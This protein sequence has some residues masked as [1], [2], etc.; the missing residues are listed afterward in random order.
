MPKITLQLDTK[1][2]IPLA[3]VI[4]GAIIALA[5]IFSGGVSLPSKSGNQPSSQKEEAK[6]EITVTKENNVQGNFE[7]PVTIIEFSDFQ[8]PFCQSFHPTLQKILAEFPNQVR[9]VYRH[10]PLDQ[11]HPQARPAAEAS[12]C[13]AEQGKFWEFADGLFENQS[14]L[15]ESFYKELASQLGLNSNQFESCIS[16]RKY[17]DKVESDYQEGIKI[18]VRGT[19]G[20][21]INGE[22]VPGGAVPYNTLKAAVERVLSQ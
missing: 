19:P 4:A 11:I 9:W 17:K 5:I 20:S 14:R 10:F 16:S 13:A 2:L 12:E 15:G 8:C 6:A 21:F 1:Y 3:I 18:G 7:S 22:P